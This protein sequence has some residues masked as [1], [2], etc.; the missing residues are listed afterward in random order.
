MRIPS[1]SNPEAPARHHLADM[2]NISLAL[3][4]LTLSARCASIAHGRYEKVPVK[5]TP[6]GAAVRVDCGDVPSDGGVTP[7]EVKLR[8]GAEH[9]AITLSKAGYAD[10]TIAF[11]R[12]VSRVAWANVAP[13]FVL[14]MGAGAAVAMG[15][16][17]DPN[18]ND[19][20]ANGAA[21]SGIVVGTG[22][23]L[24]VDRSTGAIYRQVPSTVDVTLNARP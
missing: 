14:G 6:S 2:K 7:V 16:F 23:G 15:S 1:L 11:T 17:L 3:I 12:V 18:S 24:L 9:C 8:R 13:G 22:I 4:A 5:S 10:R 20:S 19:D 21:I